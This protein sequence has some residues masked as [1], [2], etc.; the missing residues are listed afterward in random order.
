M[1]PRLSLLLLLLMGSAGAASAQAPFRASLQGKPDPKVVELT[2]KFERRLQE[3]AARLDGVAGVGVKDLASGYEFYV[4][5]DGLFPQASVIK[6]PILLKLFEDA[7]AAPQSG[8][9]LD[10]TV[11]VRASDFAPGSGVLRELGDGSVTLTLH[12]LA[13]L[14]IVLSD[15]TAT[16]ILIDRVGGLAGVNDMLARRGFVHTRLNR[17]MGIPLSGTGPEA[18]KD[19]TS[20]PRE[21]VRLLEK[22]ERGEWL[23][24]AP[25]SAARDILKK[26]KRSALR[27]AL[28]PG[29]AIANKTG[30]L[31]GARCDSGIIYLEGRPYILTI[32]T[33]Y[34]RNDE[35][36]EKF[37]EEVSRLAYDHFSRLA[38]SNPYGRRL[39]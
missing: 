1:V 34:L 27:A 39:R 21:M 4:N 35:D 33:T 30:S 36:G 9:R 2:E 8:L 17:K 37:I 6:I 15:N 19:S 28:P 16:N 29:I 20:T 32:S 10:A 14:M 12:D 38:S 5:P 23:D 26:N 3:L 24:P 25:T 7:Q 18:H 11:S 31:P 22:F 13:V